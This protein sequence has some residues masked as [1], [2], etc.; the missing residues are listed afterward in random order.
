M[1]AKV[2]TV[3]V[4]VGLIV[5]VVS[6]ASLFRMGRQRTGVRPGFQ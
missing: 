5:Y 4:F 1:I 2:R 6:V 3:T